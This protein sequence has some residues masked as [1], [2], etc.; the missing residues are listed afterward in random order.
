MVLSKLK[1]ALVE[2]ENQN[3]KILRG[4]LSRIVIAHER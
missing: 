3:T 1:Y 2:Q 4:D